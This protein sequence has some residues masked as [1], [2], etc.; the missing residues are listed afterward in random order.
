MFASL[1]G[2]VWIHHT[3]NPCFC[4][5]LTSSCSTD[6]WET[7]TSTQSVHYHVKASASGVPHYTTKTSKTSSI[8]RDLSRF[9]CLLSLPSINS[10]VASCSE[11]MPSSCFF[12]FFV[13][14][15]S[16]SVSCYSQQ[17][18][19]RSSEGSAPDAKLDCAARLRAVFCIRGSRL[20]ALKMNIAESQFVTLKSANTP[21]CRCCFVSV[22]FFFSSFKVKIVKN[23]WEGSR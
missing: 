10:N 8:P 14:T 12:F 22:L 7:E 5:Y 1:P 19:R 3:A 13:H 6:C 17:V 16:P 2:L 23:V 11:I 21:F 18:L 20:A 9:L 15:N 4:N